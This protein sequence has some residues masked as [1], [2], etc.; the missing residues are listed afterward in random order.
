MI[1]LTEKPVAERTFLR[2]TGGGCHAPVGAH[3]VTKE[4]GDLRMVVLFG[5]D[6]CSRILKLKLQ[7][8]TVRRLV[9][10]QPVC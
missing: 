4:N 6:D 2:L 8:L 3:C 7:E 9:T 1:I 5:N 10:K